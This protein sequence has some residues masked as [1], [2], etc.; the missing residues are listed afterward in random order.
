MKG[1]EWLRY[2]VQRAWTWAKRHKIQSTIL[3]LG[4]WIFIEIITLPFANIRSLKKQNPSETAF[5]VAQREQ[6]E[7][8]KKPFIKRQHW[9]SYN[10]IP[11]DV[12]N[13]V[14]VAEDGTFW[15]HSG[16]DWF[17]FR[18][19]IDRNLKEGRVAR[20]AST[21]SQ[22][23]AKNLYLSASKNP[24]RKLKEWLL[25]WYLEQTLTKTRIL[26]LYL[27]LI[28]WGPGVYGIDAAAQYHFGKSCSSLSRSEAIRL[29]VIIPNPRRF[30]AAGESRYLERMSQIIQER[31]EARGW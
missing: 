5:M 23:L 8:E 7:S 31:L 4:L 9:V 26:E 22:Q 10:R 16:F 15:E 13:A 12:I 17:E 20:G 27:N 19:S 11:K 3:I 28:E 18:A 30:Q 14:I 25:T 6:V 24:M 2:I 29:A 1:K 21:I